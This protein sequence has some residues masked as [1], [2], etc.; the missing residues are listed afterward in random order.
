MK[1]RTPLPKRFSMPA[2]PECVIS[3]ERK[4]GRGAAFLRKNWRINGQIPLGTIYRS[5][6][7]LPYVPVDTFTLYSAGNL[8][9]A[10][11]TGAHVDVLRASIH[12]GLYALY[13]G[14]PHAVGASVGVADLNTE[15]NALI[16]KLT[17]CHSSCTSLLKLINLHG[18][19]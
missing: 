12:Y 6:G 4:S 15:R 16:A 11:A 19:H 9:A 5:Q 7:D 18:S 17:F 2:W 1:G 10:K 14:L 3:F 13:I 8:A